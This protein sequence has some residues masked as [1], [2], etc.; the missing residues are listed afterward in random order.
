MDSCM[1][2]NR[3][4]PS[5]GSTRLYSKPKLWV[6][7]PLLSYLLLHLIVLSHVQVSE[8]CAHRVSAGSGWWLY[9][10]T[11][12]PSCHPRCFQWPLPLMILQNYRHCHSFCS[13]VF[14]KTHWQAKGKAVSVWMH[15]E[16]SCEGLL[17]NMT[18]SE[19]QLQNTV[20]FVEEWHKQALI[21]VQIFLLISF[22]ISVMLFQLNKQFFF[23][24]SVLL[25][26]WSSQRN[27]TVFTR[28]ELFI[29]KN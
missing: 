26:V 2:N 20:E 16:D 18:H 19:G 1:L 22:V 23:C 7:K 17:V 25:V 28:M 6:C 5:R 27:A 8:S 11:G 13:S 15:G 14:I 29:K 4:A 24:V 3:A 12:M 9:I 21:G 10:R